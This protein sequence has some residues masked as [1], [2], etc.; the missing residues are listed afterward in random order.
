MGRAFKTRLRRQEIK[1]SGKFDIVFKIADEY[2]I[3][4]NKRGGEWCGGVRVAV[5]VDG[6]KRGGDGVDRRGGKWCGGV[7]VAVA[8]DGGKQGGDGVDRVDRRWIY[9][10]II[11]VVMPGGG[12]RRLA[13]K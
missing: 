6:G 11:F 8:V 3:K 12:G 2:S 1:Q 9:L 7:R 4:V 5:A 13:E 10:F